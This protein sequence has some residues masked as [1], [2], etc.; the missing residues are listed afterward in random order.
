MD[1]LKENPFMA[2]IGGAVLL[3]LILSGVLIFPIWSD[4]GTLE[5]KIKRKKMQLN[6]ASL[7]TPG[8]PDIH[9][10]NDQKFDKDHP[11]EESDYW[12]KL[13]ASYL[14]LAKFFSEYDLLLEWWMTKPAPPENRDALSAHNDDRNWVESMRKT[15]DKGAFT[16]QLQDARKKLEEK[17]STR[18]PPVK[19][20]LRDDEGDEIEDP[21]A[22]TFGFNWED[23][24]PWDTLSR[25]NRDEILSALQKRFQIRKRIT[26]IC[27]ENHVEVKRLVD[28]YFFAKIS[29]SLR[30]IQRWEQRP[31]AG[32]GDEI[33][34]P[35][36]PERSTPDKFQEFALPGGLGKTL[37]FG[38]TVD[39]RYSEVE[40]FLQAVLNRDIQPNILINI[41]GAR[42]TLAPKYDDETGS[43]AYQN[44]PDQSF[45]Y[46]E[47][48]S[49]SETAENKAKA[50]REFYQKQVPMTVRL[51]LTCQV[52]D[53]DPSKL[54]EWAKKHLPAWAQ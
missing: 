3:F 33:F 34:Y 16:G 24:I 13:V 43:V 31:Q 28:I 39:I 44:E 46:Q 19:L 35:A 47:T 32:M 50:T 37:T 53:F 11:E 12:G 29:K 41:V 25:E 51:M 17:L 40:K 10:W 23:G 38:V 4:K 7:N 15:P 8:R 21:N 1:K 22:I 9:S 6:S 30:G 49:S 20:G 54:P 52:V 18:T 27:A 26:N 14:E 48:G 2:G 42:M 45:Q 5:T 36:I